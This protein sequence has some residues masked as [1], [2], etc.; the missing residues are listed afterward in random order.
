MKFIK[1][2]LYRVQKHVYRLVVQGILKMAAAASTSINE[3]STECV[4]L[5]NGVCSTV[6]IV[7]IEFEHCDLK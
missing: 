3:I 1:R 6:Y 7:Q 4:F 5:L 2:A